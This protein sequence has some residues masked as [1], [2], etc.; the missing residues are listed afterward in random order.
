MFLLKAATYFNVIKLLQQG[1]LFAVYQKCESFVVYSTYLQSF[2]I[3]Q[4]YTTYSASFKSFQQPC[5]VLT[6]MLEGCY[7]PEISIKVSEC[8]VTFELTVDKHSIDHIYA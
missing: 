5:K 6:T 4:G 8:D 1:K 7:N 3:M 2:C